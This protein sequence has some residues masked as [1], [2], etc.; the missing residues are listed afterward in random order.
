LL[1]EIK[2]LK[3]TAGEPAKRWFN[4]ASMDLFV[5]HEKNKIIGF[6]LCYDKEK[7][8]KALSWYKGNGFQH[9]KVDDGE[10]RSGRYKAT[11]LLLQNESFEF[12][13]ITEEF[14]KHSLHL[15]G[16]IKGF[17]LNKIKEADEEY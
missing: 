1:T 4:N 3:Q 5:W 10:N 11:P 15:V 7:N 12:N 9:Q 13:N 16:E 8:E 6:Q 14:K 17:I 2:N